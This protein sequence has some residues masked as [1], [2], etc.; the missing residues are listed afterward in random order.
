MDENAPS[1]LLV[2]PCAAA[3]FPLLVCKDPKLA[4]DL[5]GLF[6]AAARQS[7]CVECSSLGDYYTETA[8][9]STCQTCPLNTRPVGEYSL[10][11]AG[12]L[13]KLGAR[14]ESRSE[15]T[16]PTCISIVACV[17]TGFF[18]RN[19]S[20]GEVGPSQSGHAVA[21]AFFVV[22]LIAFV[23]TVSRFGLQ[24]CEECAQLPLRR[25]AFETMR[26]G[27]QSRKQP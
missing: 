20:A 24:A 19:A 15:A 17:P 2:R 26:T 18:Q 10:G 9:Q 23:A 11:K 14:P 12:C 27:R 4:L 21:M 6:A 25:F 5:S 7:Q 1:A 22:S 8:G 3:R 16:L 13:C